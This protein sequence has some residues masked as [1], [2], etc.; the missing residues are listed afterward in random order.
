MPIEEMGYWAF[1]PGNASCPSSKREGHLSMCCW[2][3]ERPARR[4]KWARCCGGRICPQGESD[5]LES[6]A[7][8]PYS[9]SDPH[10]VHL[11]NTGSSTTTFRFLCGVQGGIF[12]GLRAV[13][14]D[15][16][17]SCSVGRGV[18]RVRS[19]LQARKQIL[20]YA[21]D[22]NLLFGLAVKLSCAFVGADFV[23]VSPHLPGDLVGGL[24]LFKVDMAVSVKSLVVRYHVVLLFSRFCPDTSSDCL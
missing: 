2:W 6:G 24:R 7:G 11:F 17:E 13:E 19:V 5:C 16:G 21:Q 12:C 15:Y 14:T 3:A 20:R 4:M 18:L 9:M 1:D 10:T 22:D 8:M 23:T